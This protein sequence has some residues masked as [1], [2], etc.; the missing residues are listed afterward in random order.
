MQQNGPPAVP[1][2]PAM[3]TEPDQIVPEPESEPTPRKPRP[4]SM[5]PTSV[6]APLPKATDVKKDAE[7]DKRVS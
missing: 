6:P 7:K 4:Q 2:R 5:M 3:V 1:P